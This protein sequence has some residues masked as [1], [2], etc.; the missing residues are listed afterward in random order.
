MN[1]PCVITQSLYYL[2]NVA[3]INLELEAFG[4]VCLSSNYYQA[5]AEHNG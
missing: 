2:E 3:Q 1:N 5:M 4:Q